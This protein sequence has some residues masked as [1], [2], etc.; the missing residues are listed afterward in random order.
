MK[1]MMAVLMVFCAVM[2]WCAGAF[3]GDV[4]DIP[5]MDEIKIDGLGED[6]GDGGFRVA[7]L[8][9]PD[10]RVLPA[11]DFDA[12]FRIGWNHDGLVVLALVT[13]DMPAENE[14]LSSLW[15]MDCVEIFAS[16]SVGSSN[17]YQV[18]VASGADPDFGKLRKKVYDH[19]PEGTG[20]GD[21]TA[22]MVSRVS[23]NGYTVEMMLPWSNLG[24]TPSEGVELGFQ[25]VANDYDGDWKTS[26]RVAWYP[27]YDAHSNSTAMYAIRLSGEPSDAVL[28][29][30]DREIRFE[31]CTATVRGA[32]ELVGT[33]V[34]V[35]SG[36]KV[37]AQAKLVEDEGRAWTRIEMPVPQGS[38]A[39]PQMDV[40]VGGNTMVT[41]KPLPTL[42]SVIEKFIE[43]C[44][45]REAMQKLQTRACRGQLVTDLSWH[46]P[47]RDSIPFEAYAKAPMSWVLIHKGPG[48]TQRVG[49][50]GATGWEQTLDGVKDS[51]KMRFARLGWFLNPQGPLYMRDYFPG[52]VLV[53]KEKQANRTV[54][55]I[56]PRGAGADKDRKTLRFDVETGML[57]QIG[58]HWGLEDFREIDGVLFPYRIILG[59]KGGSSTYVFDEVSHNNDVDDA[60]FEKPDPRT[61]VPGLFDGIDDVKALPMLEHLPRVHGGMNVPARDGRFLYD[62]IIRNGYKRGLEI[63]T[64]NGYSTLWLGLAFRETGGRVITLEIDPASGKEARGNFE[65]AGLDDTIDARIADAFEEILKIEGDFDFV[66]IDA[67][68]PDYIKFWGM[69]KGRVAPGGAITAHNVSSQAR[70]MRDFLDAIKN[71]PD[72]ETTLHE[73]SPAGISV[74]IRRR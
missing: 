55:V 13:D 22:E 29:R 41:A 2:V 7:F 11:D 14:E 67:W 15:R 17:R 72:F 71:D 1:R 64:S 47:P 56:E 44:G 45:G 51:E 49:S 26:L 36:G 23:K 33:P 73:V 43:V 61:T 25:F 70:D 38:A 4:F 12:Q 53:A 3:A 32:R 31:G 16:E 10:G 62:M 24:V 28:M 18:V 54:Y 42:D 35:H 74:S 57:V 37:I 19:R 9:A 27:S 30:A 39:W 48:G 58:Y 59:R 69:L 50:D 40:V 8:A 34:E 20:A 5:K 6:W 52:M 46:D 63:G 68:K 65:K 66:F 60:L 21:L